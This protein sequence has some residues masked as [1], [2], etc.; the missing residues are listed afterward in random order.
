MIN[1]TKEQLEAIKYTDSDLLVSASAGS[2]KTRVLL[3]KVVYLLNLGYKLSDVLMVTFTKLA[4]NEM[5]SKLEN[6]LSATF[7]QTGEE[8]F[9]DALKQV[10]ASDICTIDSFCQKIV[11]KY[12]FKLNIEPNFE[13]GDEN[14]IN[15]LKNVALEDT[16]NYFINSSDSDFK[17]L[18]NLFVYKRDFTQFKNVILQFY[19]F[20]SSKP[21]KFDFAKNLINTS[22]D[23]DFNNNVIIKKFIKYLNNFL[24]YFKNSLNEIIFNAD[25]IHSEKLKD[26]AN[27]ILNI[28]CLNLIDFSDIIKTFKNKI[29]LPVIS[30][31]KNAEY[32]E[33]NLKEKLQLLKKD[34]KKFYDSITDL[35]YFDLNNL[36]NDF[37]TSKSILN[38]FVD[39]IEIFD[40]NFKKL[41]KEENLLDFSDLE[42]LTLKLLEDEN[43]KKEIS[44]SYKFIF[45]DEYQDTNSIQEEILTKISENSKKIMVGDLKQSIYSFREC[46]PK[47]FNDKLD[48]FNIGQGGK[49]INLNKN[50][51]STNEILGFSNSVFS[52]IMLK[53]NSNYDYNKDGKFLIDDVEKKDLENTMKPISIFVIDK[54]SDIEDKV[55]KENLLVVEAIYNLLNQ[56]IEEDGVERNLDYKDIAIISRK[57]SDKVIEL[58]NTLKEFKIPVSIKYKEK[59]YESFEIKLVLSY[60][61]LLDNFN[62]EISLVS[63]LKNI[64]NFSDNELIYIKQKNLCEDIFNFKEKNQTFVKISNFIEDYNYFKSL[65]CE[66]TIKNL[67]KLIIEKLNIDTIL[68][69][70]LGEISGERLN[71]FINSINDNIIELSKFISFYNKTKNCVFEINK[72]DGEN[73]V[74]IDTFHSTKG[75]EFNAVIIYSAGDKIFSTQKSSL[76]YNSEL[77]IGIYKFNEQEKTKQRNLIFSIIE[78]LQKQE[79]FNEEARLSY[80]AFTRPKHFLV[81]V[82]AENLDNLKTENNYV[83]FLNFK[84][85]LNLIFSSKLE[86]D[87][88]DI[89]KINEDDE[90][91]E[92]NYENNFLSNNDE[93]LNFDMFNKIINSS[94]GYKD[95]SIIQLKN[96]VTSLSEENKE[97]YN[98]S[99][100]KITDNDNEDYALIGN[101]YHYSLEKLPF[102]LENST[103]VKNKLVNLV[104][105]G[106]LPSS[107]FEYVDVE[108]LLKAIK[109]LSNLI[110]KKDKILKEKIFMLNISYNEIFS[111]SKIKDKILVQG[112]IDLII[113]KEDEIILID[114]KTSRLTDFNLIKKYA[115]QLNIYE[116]ALKYKYNKPIKKYIYSIFLDKLINI[117]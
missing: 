83:K 50:F 10:G 9:F 105:N 103:Q 80:V 64:Y 114:Y 67:V 89:I 75:L 23:T 37:N 116:K 65:V 91:F 32:E 104:E 53:E 109:N 60:L 66:I 31:S 81:V 17:N 110:N 51:R 54:K 56:K 47:I 92:N 100:F 111:N 85:Y 6:I 4:A 30:I 49:V 70:N 5:K 69:K 72:N 94:Y 112:I 61:K 18:S 44:Q 2:G 86:G 20:L 63:V 99:N 90:I 76:I 59:I 28:C 71:V 52:N 42:E 34:I 96:S 38:K 97:I 57:R 36:K 48:R 11:R 19:S 39:I 107:V 55:K 40:S 74:I 27:K 33:I 29:E 58:Y 26:L 15:N 84:S 95:S 98:I 62:D 78:K 41:K 21:H 88:I 87:Y 3:E 13:I 25:L 101:L 7:D 45:V 8:K 93:K 68:I 14:Y 35:I 113:E 24:N 1:F 22:Y 108:K 43:V 106:E 12:Y 46:N 16:F 82:G 102:N 79:E 117:V 115:L 73:S 77:G